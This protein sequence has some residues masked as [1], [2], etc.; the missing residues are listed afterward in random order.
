MYEEGQMLYHSSGHATRAGCR[1]HF[2]MWPSPLS[3]SSWVGTQVRLFLSWIYDFPVESNRF[4]QYSLA[5]FLSSEFRTKPRL[6]DR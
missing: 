3:V 6:E 4:R 1:L 5:Y 2:S